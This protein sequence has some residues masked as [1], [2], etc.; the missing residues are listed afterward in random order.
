M[1][2]KDI[3]FILMI[4]FMLFGIIISIQFRS[5]LDANKD[6]PSIVYQI[7]S[8]RDQLNTE[9]IIGSEL[10]EQIDEYIKKEEEYIKSI[11][12]LS[13]DGLIEEWKNARFIAGLS[14]VKGN[15]V[16]IKINDAANFEEGSIDNYVVHDRDL[17]M[18]LNELKKA[19]AQAISI[20]NER[21][22]STTEIICAGPTVRINKNRYAV[23]FEIKAIGNPKKL[24]EAIVN[25][26]I[27]MGFKD[28]G[29][30]FEVREAKNIVIPKFGGD[31][32]NLVKGLEVVE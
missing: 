21:I 28:Y 3:R 1:K 20:N 23:P 4:L 13:N 10:R 22:L 29:K 30:V 32:N 14:D 25:S 31:I 9:K 11:M 2:R 8:L 18:V 19:G 5:V 6:K 27:A 17:V 15:G 16:V 24:Y 7:E 26:P 12:N